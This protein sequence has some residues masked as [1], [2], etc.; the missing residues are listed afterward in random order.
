LAE[1]AL[2]LGYADQSH[3]ATSFKR[4]TGMTPGAFRKAFPAPS[5]YKAQS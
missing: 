3:F 5:R 4:Q 2:A 1:L